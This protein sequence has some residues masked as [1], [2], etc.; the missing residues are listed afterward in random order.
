[1]TLHDGSYANMFCNQALSA[2][3][4]MRWSE[5]VLLKQIFIIGITKE[6]Y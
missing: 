2:A 4:Q 1:M 6:R 3:T 5:F